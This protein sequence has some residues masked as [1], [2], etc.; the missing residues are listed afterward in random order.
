MIPL[1]P[2][3]TTPGTHLKGNPAE[4]KPR[5]F[6][7]RNIFNNQIDSQ[8]RRPP[9]GPLAGSEPGNAAYVRCAIYCVQAG[10][11]RAGAFAAAGGKSPLG[12]IAR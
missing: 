5:L 2:G 9:R 6:Y 8:T 7:Q 10:L 11:E 3:A 1:L 12:G 4:G